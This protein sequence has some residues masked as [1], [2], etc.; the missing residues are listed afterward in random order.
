MLRAIPTN[1]AHRICSGQVILDLATAVKVFPNEIHAKELVENALD[2]Q[3]TTI[4]INF[5][6]YGFGGFTVSDNGN[7]IPRGDFAS[8]GML[9]KLKFIR[10]A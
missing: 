9:K 2:A 7:G 10:V 5:K 6:N 8:L 4:Q 3:S 1:D